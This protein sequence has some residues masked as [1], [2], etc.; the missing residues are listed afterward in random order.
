MKKW[1]KITAQLSAGH[2]KHL[3]KHAYGSNRKHDSRRR[4]HA[5]SNC[6]NQVFIVVVKS[7]KKKILERKIYRQKYFES[8]IIYNLRLIT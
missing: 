8:S 2:S 3:N 4:S 6:V 5:F 7:F 1:T